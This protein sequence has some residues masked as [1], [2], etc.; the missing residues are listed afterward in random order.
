MKADVAIRLTPKVHRCINSRM[1][2]FGIISFK[3]LPADAIFKVMRLELIARVDSQHIHR[4]QPGEVAGLRIAA[5]DAENMINKI[6]LPYQRVVRPILRHSEFP[7]YGVIIVA[8]VPVVVEV[9]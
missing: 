2:S 5:I 8:A 4:I 7:L 1:S 3:M 6:A 9:A